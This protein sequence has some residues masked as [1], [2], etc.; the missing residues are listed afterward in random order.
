MPKP[1]SLI[2]WSDLRD[3][4]KRFQKLDQDG[5]GFV[6][7]DEL[8]RSLGRH[9]RHSRAERYLANMD[10]NEDGRVSWSEF[11]RHM[12]VELDE[13]SAST[14]DSPSSSPGAQVDRLWRD[15]PALAGELLARFRRFDGDGSGFLEKHEVEALLKSADLPCEAQQVLGILDE[16]DRSAD[17]RVSY[18]EF[19]SYTVGD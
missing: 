16:M 17:G 10:L 4:R 18:A 1:I 14:T 15:S 2:E 3:L 6:T 9:A 7:L 5:S 11:L 8:K 13:P 19:V 12:T